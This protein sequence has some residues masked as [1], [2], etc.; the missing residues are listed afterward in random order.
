MIYSHEFPLY[1]DDST[2]MNQIVYNFRLDECIRMVLCLNR[3]SIWY[4]SVESRFYKR[5]CK[6]IMF[7]LQDAPGQIGIFEGYDV[8]LH[9]N[10]K[11]FG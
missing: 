2:L 10:L 11:V 8:L 1:G 7:I 9:S 5:Y 4:S 6:C 3:D